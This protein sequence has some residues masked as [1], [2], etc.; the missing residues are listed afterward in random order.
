MRRVLFTAGLLL[1]GALAVRAAD[2]RL[3]ASIS[4]APGSA[5]SVHDG[6]KYT[7]MDAEGRLYAVEHG[8]ALK[9]TAEP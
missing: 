1:L 9:I 2:E 5:V 6:K 3:L 7:L 4:F 8:L